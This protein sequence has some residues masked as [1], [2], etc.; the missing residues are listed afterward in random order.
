MA[1]VPALAQSASRGSKHE[2]S[3]AS[4][5][6]IRMRGDLP[7]TESLERHNSKRQSEG[8]NDEDGKL[9]DDGRKRRSWGS[10]DD[11]GPLTHD[12]LHN[13]DLRV[14]GPYLCSIP[15][16]NVVVPR[17]HVKFRLTCLETDEGWELGQKILN[18]IDK[19]HLNQHGVGVR[20]SF[21]GRQSIIDPEPH[22]CLT[23]YVPAKR[24]TVDDTWLQCARE[25]RGLLISND[26]ASCSVEIVDPMVFTPVNTYP[27]LQKDKVFWEWEPLL[28]ELLVRLDLTS[29]RFIGCF[30]RGRAPTVLNCSP[31]LLILVDRNQDWTETRE[32]VVSI[33]KKWR[34]QMLAVEIVM[35]RLV[36]QAGRKGIST[37][38]VEGL[39]TNDSRTMATESNAS[40]RN[41]D[42]SDT[43][44]C[45]LSLKHPSSDEWRTFALT[46][47]HV[48]VPPFAGLSD[49]DKKLIEN[50][51]KNGI[52]PTST[53]ANADIYRLL[54]V[55]H[56]T[57]LAYGEQV[58]MMEEVIEEIEGQK[59]YQMC[60]Q[61]ERD[62]ALEML[63]GDA[64]RGYENLKS[65]INK[66]KADLQ[67]LH[68]RFENGHRLL[69]HVFSASGFKQ[70]D[71]G[72]RKDGKNHPTNLDWALVH[73]IPARQPSNRFF[74]QSPRVIPQSFAPRSTLQSLEMHGD[75][76][77]MHG[78]CSGNS[79][80]VYNGLPVA[81]IE[82]KMKEGVDTTAITLDY[83]IIGLKG[84]HFSAR[85]DSG[86]MVSHKRR[87]STGTESVIIGMVFAGFEKEGIISF[88]RADFLLDD[89]KEMTKARDT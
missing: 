68:D 89:I 83:S 44:G 24:G 12:N 23:L 51:N 73:L 18:I 58:S 3:Y 30:R 33:L 16:A 43:L 70:K 48:V 61:L 75:E 28:K 39:L 17:N 34:L 6:V 49:G 78:Y 15:T 20:F 47:W 87:T 38:L 88:T 46:C 81:N 7:D 76:V 40:S 32:K 84:E 22:P 14:G 71:L 59:K 65:D 55:D 85:G 86:A 74:D 37:G 52:L 35:D 26:L 66:Q 8:F 77:S 57:R 36:Y 56:P 25:L 9:G 11:E 5:L 31:T 29:I 41:H 82:A 42:S 21:F 2:L 27:V 13:E 10:S 53:T 72:L 1:T 69:G 50:W 60:Q 64:R 63:S 4:P 79:I 67:T 62:D 45:F 19:Y 80:G 54:G